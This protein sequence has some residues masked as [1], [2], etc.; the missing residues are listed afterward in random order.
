[1][2]IFTGLPQVL[3][4]Q[5]R[6]ELFKHIQNIDVGSNFTSVLMFKISPERD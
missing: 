6:H 1:M 5:G 2:F 3:E 4:Q